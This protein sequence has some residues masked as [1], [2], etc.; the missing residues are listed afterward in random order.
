[1]ARPAAGPSVG[2]A[3]EVA[4]MK[5]SL[6]GTLLTDAVYALSVLAVLVFVLLPLLRR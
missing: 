6:A 5:R 4:V 2:T 3:Q 1:M